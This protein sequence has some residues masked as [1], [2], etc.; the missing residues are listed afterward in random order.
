[1]KNDPKVVNRGAYHSNKNSEIFEMGT[2]GMEN[3]Q[4]IVPENLEIV[5]FPKKI[6]EILG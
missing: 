1:M 6:P 3:F 4:G 5:E 2:N